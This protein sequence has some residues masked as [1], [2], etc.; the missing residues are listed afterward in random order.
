MCQVLLYRITWSVT[1]TRLA[2][3]AS[4][5]HF[6]SHAHVERD[7]KKERKDQ[8]ATKFHLTR[9]RGAWL[10]SAKII[11]RHANFNSHAHVERDTPK[12]SLRNTA[13]NFNSHAHVERDFKRDKP[14]DNGSD[15]NSHSHVERDFCR[16]LPT[17]FHW[18]F[19]SHAHVERDLEN[20][21]DYILSHAIST[22]TLTWS[23][24]CFIRCS[25]LKCSSF[26]LTRSRGAWRIFNLSQMSE[27]T[28]STH[29][30]TWSVTLSRYSWPLSL[31]L[32]QLTRSRG[33]WLIEKIIVPINGY[34]S[35]HTLT[36]S[37]TFLLN[38][39]Q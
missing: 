27:L 13:R 38:S 16:P 3:P 39:L 36:W 11:E 22:H 7:F 21:T 26:Q 28:I 9:S 20:R 18:N 34:I 15:F 24:T 29:T 31:C 1:R 23:V 30:L 37:V 14:L 19:N 33:A 2:L 12:K 32:F 6:N 4:H 10:V 5:L 8:I 25:V 17:L 35:T